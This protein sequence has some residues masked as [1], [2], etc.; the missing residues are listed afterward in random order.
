MK[1]TIEV[2]ESI[3]KVEP[4][5]F[6]YQRILSKIEQKKQIVTSKEVLLIGIPSFVILVI[7]CFMFF[8][9][10]M[11]SKKNDLINGMHLMEHNS[12]Y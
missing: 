1:P 5:P 6:L 12:L 8:Q 11:K 4:S 7:T 10:P 2:L 3:N 9:K